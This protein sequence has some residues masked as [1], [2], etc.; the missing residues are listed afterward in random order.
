LFDHS[1]SNSLFSLRA[2][3]ELINFHSDSDVGVSKLAFLSLSQPKDT[4]YPFSVLRGLKTLMFDEFS[5]RV[6]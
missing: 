1:N 6:S 5:S 4:S 3:D 2:F